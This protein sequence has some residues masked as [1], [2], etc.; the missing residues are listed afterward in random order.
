[1]N[2]RDLLENRQNVHRK[3][4][5]WGCGESSTDTHFEFPLS[6]V[7]KSRPRPAQITVSV[8]QRLIGETKRP[9]SAQKTVFF[10]QNRAFFGK[11]TGKIRGLQLLIRQ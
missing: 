6:Q 7:S 3:Q 4:C 5:L 2:Y 1:M 10:D 11:K 9:F 8:G